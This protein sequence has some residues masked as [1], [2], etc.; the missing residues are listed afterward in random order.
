[1]SIW[2]LLSVFVILFAS[3][4]TSA[5]QAFADENA[6]NAGTSEMAQADGTACQIVNL[7]SD[8]W[9]VVPNDDPGARIGTDIGF[10][11]LFSGVLTAA[12]TLSY[13]G[14]DQE[15]KDIVECGCGSKARKYTY[16]VSSFVFGALAM[17]LAPALAVHTSHAIWGGEGSLGWTYLGGFLGGVVGMGIGAA[18]WPVFGDT[19]QG[20][21]LMIPFGFLGGMTGAILGYELTNSKNWEAKY[22]TISKIYP[23]IELGP[24]RNILGVG[25][26][27]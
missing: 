15:D 2:H 9:K 5:S 3:L 6:A 12:S 14:Y 26:E 10:G 4:F 17:S 19:H 1:M 23:V 8:D 13:F 21:W 22:G 25:M 11:L 16:Y 24:E 18:F 27:F 7:N 20:G